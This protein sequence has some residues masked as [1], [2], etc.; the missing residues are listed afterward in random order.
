MKC[1]GYLTIN[2]KG[3]G[4]FTKNK[5]GTAW[6]EIS[7]R[8]NVDI[9]DEFFVKPLLTANI[10]VGDDVVPKPQPTELI[11]NTAKLI[12]QSTGAKIEFSVKPYEDEE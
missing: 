2:H 9:P 4:R 8:L 5:V 6:D 12:E 10:K 3:V 7:I 11:L 1:E